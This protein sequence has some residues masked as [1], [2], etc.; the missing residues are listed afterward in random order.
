MTDDDWIESTIPF[1]A[2]FS[3]SQTEAAGT[4]DFTDTGLSIFFNSQN[5]AEI[6]V[7]RID[8]IP[9]I[10]PSE[11]DTVFDAQYWVVNRYGTGSFDADLTFTLSEDL[12]AEDESDPS[13]ISLFTRS[14]TADTN[15]V[16]LTNASSVNA[17]GNK[18]TFDGITDF[19]QFIVGRYQQSLDS[20][21]NVTIEINGTEV[22]LS[23]DE[24]SGANSY[25]IFASDTPNGTFSDITSQGTF[26]RKIVI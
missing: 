23:W 25:K 1:G 15:W 3:D 22:Q 19:S 7:T 2:G 6:T 11:P 5:G 14:S 4:V 16:Y 12:T 17:A 8:T 10:N 9:N 24:V 20:P 18:A 26:G 13:R 21:Q